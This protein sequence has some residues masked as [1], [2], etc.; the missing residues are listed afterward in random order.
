MHEESCWAD[1]SDHRI[2]VAFFYTYFPIKPNDNNVGDHT[3]WR[4]MRNWMRANRQHGGG[5]SD[6][7]QWLQYVLEH[8]I[9]NFQRSS[10][11]NVAILAGDFNGSIGSRGGSHG[12]IG[13]WVGAAGLLSA[14]H[15]VNPISNACSY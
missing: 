3:L 2:V 13:T 11:N 7:V 9:V 5:W 15:E 8:R 12:D 10:A 14:L 6:P 4:R 1:I